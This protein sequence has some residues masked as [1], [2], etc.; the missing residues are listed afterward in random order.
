MNYPS[1]WMRPISIL[2]ILGAGACVAADPEDGEEFEFRDEVVAK[3]R[4]GTGLINNGLHDPQVGGF[5]PAYALVTKQGL[6]GG[7]LGDPDRLATA[8]YVVECA[9]G[10]GESVAKVV[11]G[12]T[13][14]FEGALGL[15]PQW[16]TGACD[17][18]CQ[19]WVSAC[20]LARTNV[21]GQAVMLWL[22]ADH[23]AIGTDSNPDFPSYEASFFGNLF[24]ASNQEYM[25]PGP[26]VGPLLAQLE[27]RTCSNVVGG[28][29]GFTSYALCDVTQRCQFE[30]L[31]QP[32]AKNCR[33]GL[34]PSGPGL[35]TISTY[36]AAPL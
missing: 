8:E 22:Q 5:D 16:R 9:L 29:C 23:P 1:A 11:G 25:C 24:A 28:W 12:V 36:V 33:K 32:T 6:D 15:A 3:D 7:K 10:E 27:G 35:N 31:L 13:M 34:F 20:V 18:D 26:L 21:S 19:E 2:W 30:G 17:V 14:E 4:A